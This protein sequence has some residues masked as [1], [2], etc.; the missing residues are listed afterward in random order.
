MIYRRLDSSHDMTF[1]NGRGN[2]LSGIESV[3]QAIK[4]RLLLFQEEWLFDRNDG[5]PLFQSI[6]GYAGANKAAVERVIAERILGTQHVT[7]I[8]HIASS[9]DPGSRQYTFTA[10]VDTDFGEVALSSVP[11]APEIGNDISVNYLI[12]ESGSIV[13]DEARRAMEV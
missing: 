13:P 10:R 4:T 8:S 9:Y 2:F 12:D 5:L 3:A 11:F 1:G 6:L 7:G